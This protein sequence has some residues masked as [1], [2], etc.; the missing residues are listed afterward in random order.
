MCVH[1]LLY[2]L[3]YT[4]FYSLFHTLHSSLHST[5]LYC[6][7]C[8]QARALDARCTLCKAVINQLPKNTVVSFAPYNTSVPI[9]YFKLPTQS[10]KKVKC[11]LQEIFIIKRANGRFLKQG[12][13]ISSK[14]NS[15]K[16]ENKSVILITHLT[17][18]SYRQ[19]QNIMAY[20][21][22]IN[23]LYFEELVKLFYGHFKTKQCLY[24]N[25][26]LLVHGAFG[27]LGIQAKVQ[28][29]GLPD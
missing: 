11:H 12:C 13:Y 25:M 24:G 15:V 7:I 14:A 2:S 17:D 8:T 27:Q 28:E 4:L 16:E 20:P 21:T 6:C 10:K 23:V 1:T 18:E 5:L 22:V 19:V 3:L 9:E 26:A 29:T